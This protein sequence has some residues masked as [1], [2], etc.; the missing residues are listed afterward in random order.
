MDPISLAAVTSALAVLATERGKGLASSAGKDLWDKIKAK[1]GWKDVPEKPALAPTIAAR[2]LSDEALAAEIV[3][4][5]KHS[6]PAD[7]SAR[8]LVGSIE[9]SDGKVVVS[10]QINVAGDFVM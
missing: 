8:S 2:L 3:E 5:L 7:S 4:L 10:Q 9:A 1:F 6:T